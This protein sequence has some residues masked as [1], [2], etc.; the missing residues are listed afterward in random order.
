MTNANYILT[1]R[2]EDNEDQLLLIDEVVSDNRTIFKFDH[3]A[4]SNNSC[5]LLLSRFKAS[6]SSNI[7]P[8]KL[9]TVCGNVDKSL[10]NIE[11]YKRFFMMENEDEIIDIVQ[12]ESNT[13]EIKV[14][15]YSNY[16]PRISTSIK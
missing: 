15:E 7:F 12:D 1:K 2:G 14:L 8:F 9:L 11:D 10:L 6:F 4:I 13:P 5:L 16:I 3:V